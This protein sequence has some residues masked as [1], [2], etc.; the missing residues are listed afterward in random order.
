M[1][2][3]LTSICAMLRSGPGPGSSNTRPLIVV[4]ECAD[5]DCAER[6]EVTRS[7]YEKAR[8][9][10]RQFIVAPQHADPEIEEVVLRTDRF[11]MVRK[12]GVG[13]RIAARLDP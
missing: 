9:D 1:R 5:E 6:L 10:P 4:C 8:S 3:P 13:A 7:D 2:R 12:I 11:E